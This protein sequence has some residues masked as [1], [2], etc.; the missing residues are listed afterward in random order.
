VLR[1]GACMLAF[2]ALV[3]PM[4]ALRVPAVRALALH[5]CVARTCP[6]VRALAVRV[7][8]VRFR[9]GRVVCLCSAHLHRVELA[10]TASPSTP[11]TC[12]ALY[13]SPILS[14]ICL[15]LSCIVPPSL[16]HFL[17]VLFLPFV[18]FLA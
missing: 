11:A 8:A 18:P 7:R 5:A 10:D 2:C 17:F 16:P 6:A 9:A 3:P 4:P 14:H 1:A 13:R 12:H 15:L